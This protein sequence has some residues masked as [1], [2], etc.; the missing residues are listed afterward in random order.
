MKRFL[1][2]ASAACLLA[3]TGAL[4]QS[5]SVS[6]YTLLAQS[7][8][9]HYVVLF[10]LGKATLDATAKSTIAAAAQEFQRT[11]A[12][13]L[14]V[15]GHTDTSG[16]ADFNQ[17]LSERREQ[18][19]TDELTRLGVPASAIHGSA[20]GETDPA[21]PTGDGIVEAQNR[22]VEITVAAPPPPAVAPAPELAP[23]PA[24]P[25][26]SAPPAPHWLFGVGL[27]YGYNL[28]DEQSTHSQL[29][30]LN[31]SLDYQVNDWMTFGIEQAGFYHFDTDNDGAAG[32]TMIGPDFIFGNEDFQGYIG[33]NIGLI[34]GSGF[35]DDLAGGPEVGF[36]AGIFD[37]KVAYDIP[38]NR[39]LDEGIIN[40]TLGVVFRF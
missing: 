36:R 3:P 18:A 30:G 2:C 5:A 16:N 33:G 32:R 37:W 4:A 27:F 17:R 29:A 23:A 25:V 7:E 38:F 26:A 11:G 21:V 20:R 19:V 24:P 9:S 28:E 15:A 8:P 22:R 14:A 10:A 13:S 31:F 35:D 39:D 12:A 34:Y 40:T 1:L 6:S